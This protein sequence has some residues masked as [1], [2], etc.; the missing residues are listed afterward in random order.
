MCDIS[1][2][3]LFCFGFGYTATVLAER[4]AE[5][6]EVTVSGTRTRLDR[7]KPEGV[8]LAAFQGDSRSAE[9]ARLV[10][11]ATHVLV[12]I[13]PDLEGCPALRLHGSDLA[14][15]AVTLAAPYFGWPFESF[16]AALS[17]S[18][19]LAP[20]STRYMMPRPCSPCVVAFQRWSPLAMIWRIK[21]GSSVLL[22]D[23]PFAKKGIR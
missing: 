2:M 1:V 23:P 15:C 11:G 21:H 14:A 7:P 12:S 20:S 17:L 22:R 10:A 8:R 16:I 13:P 3:N 19:N 5:R 6:P 4:L 18:T 9:V